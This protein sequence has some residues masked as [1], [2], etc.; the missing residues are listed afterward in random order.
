[1]SRPIRVAIV[2]DQAPFRQ[3]LATVL[4]AEGLHCVGEAAD[5]RDALWMVNTTHPDVVLMDLRMPGIGGVEAT[6]R[7]YSAGC[8]A[9]VIVLTT[10]D[11]DSLVFDA[12]RAGAVG[13][14]LKGLSGAELAHAIR[15]THRGL[16]V[17]APA[18]GRKV[19]S[20]FVR[21][22][23]LTPPERLESF[24]LSERERQVL[25]CMSTGSSNKEIALTLGV[26]EGTIK[27]HVSRILEKLGAGS[28]TEAA[29][30]ARENGIA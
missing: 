10:F 8:E 4:E 26:A 29:L 16:S 11:E 23:R 21:M 3:G 18:I 30:L 25:R 22:A 27:N 14:L 6:R 17:L 15:A 20:E 2:D 1:M 7:L 12:L 19:V 5:G 13:Y 28:R 24:G 9:S